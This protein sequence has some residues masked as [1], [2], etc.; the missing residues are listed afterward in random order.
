[1]SQRLYENEALTQIITLE[2]CFDNPDDESEINGDSGQVKKKHLWASI[3]QTTLSG[4]INDS[5]TT[6]P[7]TA[8]RFA[9]TNLPIIR[10]GSEKLLITGGWGTTSLTCTRGYHNTSAA[11]HTSGDSVYLAYDAQNV[12]VVCEDNEGADEAPWCVYCLA[13]GGVADN[14]YNSHPEK[15]SLG[16]IAYNAKVEIERKFT[17][18]AST[19]PI[20]KQDLLHKIDANLKECEVA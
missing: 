2:N 19:P 8:A 10:I 13:P 3:E 1:M 15:L 7:L 20:D 11:A 5:V 14:N 17:V 18:P 16:N 9:D 4:N 12:Q 6:I